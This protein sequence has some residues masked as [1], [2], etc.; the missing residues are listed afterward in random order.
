MRIINY[1]FYLILTASVFLMSCSETNKETKQDNPI[2]VKLGTAETRTGRGI[3]ASGQIASEKSIDISTR[4]MGFVTGIYVKPG[5]KV[6]KG[7][8]LVTISNDDILAKR[9]QAKAMLSEAE[10][11]LADAQKDFNRFEELYGQQSASEKEFENV[12]LHLNSMKSKAEAARQMEKEAEAMLVYTN[13]VAPFAGVITAKNMDVGGM[14]NPG[15]P[16][17]IMEQVGNYQVRASVSENDIAEV[18]QGAIA[19][20]VIKSQ[21]RHIK[22][23]VTELSPSSQNSGQYQIK[24]SIPEQENIGLYTGMYVNVMIPITN[25]QKADNITL[26]PESA[27]AYK[28]QLAGV[29]TISEGQQALLRW[30][31]L[32]KTY[33]DQI[34]IISG[35][36]HD[37]KFILESDG[38]LYNGV[39]VI[40]R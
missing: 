6:Q 18:K 5:D 14:A 36:R 23:M 37:E 16:I 31:K 17:L 15:M 28:D 8:L 26:V 4:I 27:I 39:P 34:E 1:T 11:A 22:G 24:V 3:Y 9:A 38:K 21:N 33:D 20:I 2:G 25:T 29:F 35:L 40:V 32:G 7:K 12:T 30:V 10:A 19:E 13:L